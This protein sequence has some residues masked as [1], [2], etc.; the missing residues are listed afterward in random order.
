MEDC[1]A[2]VSAVLV[3]EETLVRTAAE[4]SESFFPNPC[5]FKNTNT[6]TNS[7][8]NKIIPTIIGSFS[9]STALGG[10]AS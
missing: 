10:S 7:T 3:S 6:Q 9:R 4:D 5:L 8:I 2:V 1:V